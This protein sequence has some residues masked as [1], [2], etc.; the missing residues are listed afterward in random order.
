MSD[1]GFD[2]VEGKFD[3]FQNFV[4][5]LGKFLAS[6]GAQSVIGEAE[7]DLA[8]Y[9]VTAGVKNYV[10]QPGERPDRALNAAQKTA[11]A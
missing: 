1:S 11:I 3:A 4:R 6:A 10:G 2:Q 5:G 9:H 7:L 8:E